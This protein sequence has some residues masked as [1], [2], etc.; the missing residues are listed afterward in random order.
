MF[1]LKGRCETKMKSGPTQCPCSFSLCA[2][3][4]EPFL[5][6]QEALGLRIFVL[7]LACKRLY[8]L[9]LLV[10]GGRNTPAPSFPG[11]RLLGSHT[12]RSGGA[13]KGQNQGPEQ[14]RPILSS[15][16]SLQGQPYPLHH[17]YPSINTRCSCLQHICQHE[18]LSSVARQVL[19]RI[20]IGLLR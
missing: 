1:S 9:Q 10:E 3:T 2:P 14:L 13:G 18:Q 20:L 6:Q 7:L 15:P 16:L 4:L 19:G 11:R 5:R 12:R 17:V 8:P